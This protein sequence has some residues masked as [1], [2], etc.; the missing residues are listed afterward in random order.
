M[1]RPTR[2]YYPNAFV[3]ISVR[4]TQRDPVFDTNHDFYRFV[5]LLGK[6]CHRFDWTCYSFCGLPHHYQL[7]ICTHSGEV[8]LGMKWLNGQYTV[9]TNK[10]RGTLGPLFQ[11]RYQSILIDPT[12]HLQSACQFVMRQPAQPSPG[13][14]HHEWPWS[15][16]PAITN[17]TWCPKWLNKHDLLA[18]YDPDKKT[19]LAAFISHMTQQHPL[20]HTTL[21]LPAQSWGSAEFYENCQAQPPEIH[22]ISAH[23][24]ILE[25]IKQKEPSRPQAMATAY[26]D[27]RFSLNDIAAYFGVHYSTVSRAVQQHTR[28]QSA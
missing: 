18:S 10:S 16:Y 19:A 1:G 23:H 9:Q 6:T 7:V 13:I 15:S 5:E 25:K 22:D 24:H 26:K 27:G 8:A 12:T 20:Q 3:Y 28:S 14:P 21:P 11:G 17:Q 4:G 2:V